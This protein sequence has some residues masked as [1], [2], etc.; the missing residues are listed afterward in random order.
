MHVAQDDG[1]DPPLSNGESLRSTC[2]LQ[3]SVF[4]LTFPYSGHRDVRAPWFP[5]NFKRAMQQRF[6][7]PICPTPSPPRPSPARVQRLLPPPLLRRILF[8]PSVRRGV[9]KVA[10]V[11]RHQ[12]CRTEHKYRK[13]V[14]KLESSLKVE[15]QAD[16][17]AARSRKERDDDP[18]QRSSHPEPIC[19]VYTSISIQ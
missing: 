8:I 1:K 11:L 14:F 17:R 13:H 7:L 10:F 15:P 5:L 12:D 4:T 9:I 19:R 6:S 3:R 18:Q 2:A 16:S